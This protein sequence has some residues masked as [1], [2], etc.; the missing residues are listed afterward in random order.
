[1]KRRII[2]LF[3]CSWDTTVCKSGCYSLLFYEHT[4]MITYTKQNLVVMRF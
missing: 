3:Y 2:P 1:M 4:S